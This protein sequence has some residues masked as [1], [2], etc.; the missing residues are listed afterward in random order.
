MT[1][2]FQTGAITLSSGQKSN[3]KIECDALTDEDLKTLAE[4]I[5]SRYE[6]GEVISIPTGGDKLADY[7]DEYID[8]E[9]PICLLVDDVLTTGN[10]MEKMKAHLLDYREEENIQGVVIFARGIYLDWITAVF[11]MWE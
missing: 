11:K 9:S 2:L 10:S 7:L 4:L 6:F 5:A 8:T 3:F 1:N